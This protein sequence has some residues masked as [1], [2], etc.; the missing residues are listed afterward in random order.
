[1]EP[2]FFRRFGLRVSRIGARAAVALVLLVLFAPVAGATDVQR[3]VSPGGIEAWLVEAHEIPVL[4]VSIAFRGGAATDPAGKEGLANMVSGLLDEGAGDL[5]SQAFQSRLEDL[6]IRL[7]FDAGLDS[8][9]VDLKTL[10]E[11]T[12]EAFRLLGLALARPRFDPGPVERVRAQIQVGLARRQSDPNYIARRTWFAAAF[13]NHPY[14]RPVSGTPESVARLTIDDLRGFMARA[15]ARDRMVIG[16][17]GD[18]TPDKLATL[19]D[20]TFGAL[21]EKGAEI[22]VPHAT[23]Q[24]PGRL[25]VKK[26]PIPQSIVIFGGEGLRRKDPDYYAAYVMNHILGGGGFTSRLTNEVRE[27]RGLAYGVYSYLSPLDHAELFLGRV[28]TKNS[29][30]AE[31]IRIIR[32]EIAR[33]RDRGA[34]EAELAD[35]KTYLT[36]SFPLRLDTND[37]IAGMLVGIQLEGLGIDYIDKRNGYIEAVTLA[38]VN[39][40]AKRLL[41]PEELEIVVVGEPEGIKPTN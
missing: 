13:P 35:A 27:K 23:P 7:S 21:P 5:D 31:S 18:I 28:A 11:N 32:K 6:A 33:M 14:G 15:I 39:R 3:V 19:L 22:D 26:R 2:A 10:S 36:G 20:S 34:T 29:R 12:D 24:A 4:S 9:D 16:V 8:F 41:K 40:M 1:M 30:V 17:S 38:D 37:K 25:I